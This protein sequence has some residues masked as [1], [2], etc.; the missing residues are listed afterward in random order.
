MIFLGRKGIQLDADIWKLS[1]NYL[2]KIYKF[3]GRV[4]QIYKFIN[5]G[6][7]Q[8]YKYK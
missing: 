4:K 6:C 8:I 7:M 2:E 1:G 3:F 5:M